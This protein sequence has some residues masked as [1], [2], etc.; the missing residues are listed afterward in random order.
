MRPWKPADRL[1]LPGA[2]PMA[3]DDSRGE[4]RQ[5]RLACSARNPLGATDALPASHLNIKVKSY[6]SGHG[7]L[8][9][10]AIP[11]AQ[12]IL[13]ANPDLNVIAVTSDQATLGAEQAVTSA[14]RTGKIRLVSS[15]GSCPAVDAV[16]AG[17][18]WMTI[19]DLPETEGKLAMQAI[20]DSIRNGKNGPIG[21]NPVDT[22]S[23]TII[24]KDKVGSFRCEWEG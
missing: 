4:R 16:K 9:A 8:A 20:V 12:N 15:G 21:K 24:T 10:P 2:G 11:I 23:N 3:R 6:Q 5:I 13:Q 7:Y 14:G 19:A 1:S 18:F 22:I 17:R